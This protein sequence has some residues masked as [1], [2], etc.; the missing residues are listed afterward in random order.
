M[1]QKSWCY[2]NSEGKKGFCTWIQHPS[3]WQ[4]QRQYCSSISLLPQLSFIAGAFPLWISLSLFS[5]QVWLKLC[6]VGFLYFYSNGCEWRRGAK[7]RV[8]SLSSSCKLQPISRALVTS[9]LSG[10]SQWHFSQTARPHTCAL[11]CTETCPHMHRHK[12]V[13]CLGCQ[14][15]NCHI[16]RAW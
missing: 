14:M 15:K 7:T 16:F 5:Q 4:I 11:R 12:L 2:A 1:W 3:S 9:Q 10:N 13:S 8:L 6:S